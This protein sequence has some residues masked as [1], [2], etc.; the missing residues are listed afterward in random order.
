MS[1][2]KIPTD[3]W[4]A[5]RDRGCTVRLPGTMFIQQVQTLD[6]VILSTR[7]Q[8]EKQKELF[9]MWMSLGKMLR[10]FHAR[11]LFVRDI[12]Y[13]N[14]VKARMGSGSGWTLLEFGN[15]SRERSHGVSKGSIPPRLVAP[16]VRCGGCAAVILR[17]QRGVRLPGTTA[18][19][20]LAP[21]MQLRYDAMGIIAG[22]MMHWHL[23]T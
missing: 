9:N 5:C 6:E 20:A 21:R 15:V 22:D 16:E 1:K 18:T 8:E 17:L 12:T 7:T 23:R 13:G 14:V 4:L 10:V 11:Q 3:A 19:Q 2:F